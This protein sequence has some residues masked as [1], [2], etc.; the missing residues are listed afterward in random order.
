MNRFCSRNVVLY[1]RGQ[2]QRNV[3]HTVSVPPFPCILT[4]PA[5][6][7]RMICQRGETVT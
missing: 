7:K 3:I 4:I 5:S 1:T 6:G 2:C